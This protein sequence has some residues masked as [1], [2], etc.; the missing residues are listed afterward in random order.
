MNDLKEYINDAVY[1]VKK[2]LSLKNDDLDK[3]IEKEFKKAIKNLRKFGII[4]YIERKYGINYIEPELEILEELK[5]KPSTAAEYSLPENKIRISKKAIEREIDNQLKFL[6]YKEIKKRSISDIQDIIYYTIYLNGSSKLLCPLRINGR[7]II[8]DIINFLILFKAYHEY[9]HSIDNMILQ[10]LE[11][12][13]TIKDRDYLLT[14][15]DDSNIWELR[16]SAFGF[17]INYLVN[18]LHKHE[19]GYIAAYNN[20]LI[21]RDYIG[22]L[23]KLEKNENTIENIP[24]DLG[25]C[26]GS[27]LVFPNHLSLEE[28]INNIIEDIIHLDIERAINVIM[29][30]GDTLVEWYYT[31]PLYEQIAQMYAAAY[32]VNLY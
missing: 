21:C 27:V 30:Y 1:N 25:L 11:K 6:D 29:A 9:W 31:M 20:I 7:S 24:Y 13:S 19:K 26:Y 23:D 15:L 3:I 32:Y 2:A 28:N 18:G 8:E 22:K 4:E 14:I 10:K 5:G 12:D 16:A 17:V